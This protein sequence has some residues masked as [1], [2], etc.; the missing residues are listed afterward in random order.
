MA[1]GHRSHRG[2][3]AAPPGGRLAAAV[4][5]LLLGG[6]LAALPGAA[7]AGEMARSPRPGTVP[8]GL[9]SPPAAPAAP[10]APALAAAAAESSLALGERAL[11]RGE[12]DLALRAYREV[13]RSLSLGPRADYGE[14]RCWLALGQAE[15]AVRALR[16]LTTPADTGD[17]ARELARSAAELLGQ[18]HLAMGKPGL[19]RKVFLRLAEDDPARREWATVMIARTL[20]SEESY[21]AAADALAP[22]LRAGRSAPAYDLAL[23]LY[24]KLEGRSQRELGRLLQIYLQASNRPYAG[25]TAP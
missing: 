20:E 3:D 16:G 4:C 23:D 2:E 19:A 24:W 22:L 18:T 1:S 10:A 12:P 11:A 17:A 14:A 7:A 6:L 5:A 25:V 13:P 8:A 9:T 21:V 15:R